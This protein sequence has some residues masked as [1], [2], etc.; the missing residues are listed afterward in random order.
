[1]LKCSDSLRLAKLETNGVPLDGF[2]TFTCKDIGNHT[3]EVVDAKGI[4]GHHQVNHLLAGG[5]QASL[6]SVHGKCVVEGC[7]LF[8]QVVSKVRIPEVARA[9]AMLTQNGS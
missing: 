5:I 7:A 8:V 6:P 1:M 3:H 2:A 4:L 9:V